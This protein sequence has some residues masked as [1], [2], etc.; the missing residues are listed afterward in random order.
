MDEA[1][2]MAE[3]I[4]QALVDAILAADI[5]TVARSSVREYMEPGQK[6]C[7]HHDDFADDQARE[8]FDMT[9]LTDIPSLKRLVFRI[10]LVNS[11]CWEASGTT[12]QASTNDVGTL[13]V[14]RAALILSV[15]QALIPQNTAATDGTHFGTIHAHQRL[16]AAN[17]ATK[18]NN[19]QF[20]LHLEAF[21]ELADCEVRNALF[22]D[23]AVAVN[24]V[25]KRPVLNDREVTI[26]Q[27][28]KPSFGTAISG[29][30]TMLKTANQLIILSLIALFKTGHHWTPETV[31]ILRRLCGA[32]GIPT[33]YADSVFWCRVV[34]HPMSI[35]FRIAFMA[36]LNRRSPLRQ[37]VTT[38][39][40]GTGHGIAKLNLMW[41]IV[42]W[43]RARGERQYE[44]FLY[45]IFYKATRGG[46]FRAMMANFR[47]QNAVHESAALAG[48]PNFNRCALGQF[49][50]SSHDGTTVVQNTDPAAR[51]WYG[52]RRAEVESIEDMKAPVLELI[53]VIGD[54]IAQSLCFGSA[55]G[56][57]GTQ[58][59]AVRARLAEIKKGMD[60]ATGAAALR[61]GGR[62]LTPA[63]ITAPG[64]DLDALL[65]I[66]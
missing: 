61:F 10:A 20:T 11:N 31:E 60:A 15:I 29:M 30:S 46:A 37:E 65:G 59:D 28:M 35:N 58:K 52:L 7:F 63:E 57:P 9:V 8:N 32:I 24:L 12:R 6:F 64:G 44:V 3:A 5:E 49:G 62:L 23:P 54:R 21:M 2:I 36:Y 38:R 33:E 47:N 16:N 42:V 39:C 13:S 51:A 1:E 14:A 27:A 45:E 53:A 50:F 4:D 19:G 56:I 41:A 22:Q 48:V 40:G 26:P 43:A 18:V 66:A 25:A 17:L 34:V 55:A